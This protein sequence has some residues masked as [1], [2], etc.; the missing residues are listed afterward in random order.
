M[1]DMNLYKNNP[2]AGGADGVPVVTG[3]PVR[4]PFLDLASDE[5]AD[6]VLALR[7]STGYR[8]RQATVITPTAA[9]TT[10]AAAAAAGDQTI[11]A[12]SVGGLVVNNRIAIGSGD[13]QEIKRIT[14]ISDTTI[15]L[16]SVLAN[17]QASGAAVV[18]QSKYQIALA[19]DSGGVAGTF[20]DFGAALTLPYLD[21]PE[22]LQLSTAITGGSLAAGDYA[23]RVSAYDANGETIACAAATITVPS[24]TSTNTVM[25]SW[26]AVSGATGYKV[27]GR[28]AGSTLLIATVTTN[29]YTDNGSVTPSGA[30]PTTSAVQITD[31]NTLVHA[32][33]RA[34]S[35]EVVPY[36]DPSAGLSIAYKVGEV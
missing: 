5:T 27:Y 19:K 32:R 24:G 22:N 25:L 7:C 35:A 34:V 28:T 31:V 18:C 17:A 36:N 26:D 20:G 15:T 4:T 8:S 10:L 33:F 11:S 16:D 2:T 1:S 9:E 21:T 23:Y 29:T 13:T 6:I 14:A 30:L 12:A 3:N